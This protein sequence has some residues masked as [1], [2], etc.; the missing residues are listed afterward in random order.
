MLVRVINIS[1]NASKPSP[2][3]TVLGTQQEDVEDLVEK[4][5]ELV[6]MMSSTMCLRQEFR[7][8][9][10]RHSPVLRY[11]DDLGWPGLGVVR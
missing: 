5:T 2:V 10:H 3:C 8:E 4:L 11:V 9:A 7:E 6:S 1:R